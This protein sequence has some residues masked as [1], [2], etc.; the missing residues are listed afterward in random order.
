ML[1]LFTLTNDDL[2]RLNPIEAVKVFRRLLWAEATANGISKTLINVPSAINVADGGIDAEI[3]NVEKDSDQGIIKKGFTRYQIKTGNFNINHDVNINE[4]LFKKQSIEEKKNNKPKELKHR[5]HSCLKK[6]GHLVIVL[7]GWDNPEPV[8]DAIKNKF[9]IKLKKININ[10]EKSKIYIW[11]QNQII[12]FFESFP[13]LKLELISRKLFSFCTYNTWSNWQDMKVPFFQGEN[14]K[15]YLLNLQEELRRERINNPIRVLGEPGIGKTRITLEAIKEDDL[16]PITIYYE[17]PEQLY[18]DKFIFGST[19]DINNYSIILVVD[20]CNQAATSQIWNK[21]KNNLPNIKLVTIFD[22]Y[23]EFTEQTDIIDILPLENEQIK[24]IFYSYLGKDENVN[25]WAEYCSG[26][27]RVAHILGKNLSINSENLL[28]T[29][30]EVD[31]WGIYIAGKNNPNSSEEKKKRN[32]LRYISLFKKFGFGPPFEN[33]LKFIFN[34]IEENHSIKWG[35]FIDIIKEFK[36]R[37][38]LQGSKTLYITPKLLHIYL[39]IEYWNN[40]GSASNFNFNQFFQLCDKDKKDGITEESLNQLKIWFND[41]FKYAVESKIAI[42]VVE[43]ILGPDGPFK[44]YKFLD[45]KPG[46]DFFLN[47]TI[48]SPKYALKC[49]QRLFRNKTKEELLNFQN[50]RRFIIWAL[51]RIIVWRNLFNEGM[52]LLLALAE[53]ENESYSNNATGI[54][55]SRFKQGPRP[56]ATTEA[57]SEER[58]ELLEEVLKSESKEKRIIG[59]KACDSALQ[60]QM[61]TRHIGSEYQGLKKTPE[62][63]APRTY[64]ELWDSYIRVWNLLFKFIKVVEKDEKKLIIEIILRRLRE[65]AIYQN[66][67]DMLIEGI[68]YIIKNNY[69]TEEP[70]L[71]SIS[72]IIYFDGKKMKPEILNKWQE[73]KNKLVGDDFSSLLKR[74]VGMNIRYEGFYKKGKSFSEEDKKFKNQ[75]KDLVKDVIKDKNLLMKELSWLMTSNAKNGYFFGVELGN[76][77]K[78]FSLLKILIDTFKKIK[79]NPDVSFLSGYLNSIYSTDP[80]KFERL[81]D[82]FVNDDKLNTW[83]PEISL[84]TYLSD[85]GVIRILKLAKK[86]IIKTDTFSIFRYGNVT[87]EISLEIF[88]DLIKYLLNTKELSGLSV[89]L[90][91][92]YHYFDNEKNREYLPEEITKDILINDL[93]FKENTKEKSDTMVEY[94]WT[95][96]GKKYL[97]K[98]SNKSIKIAEIIIKNFDKDCYLFNYYSPPYEL[99]NEITYTYPKEIW[100]IVI[101]YLKL[102]NNKLEYAIKMWLE[103]KMSF[104]EEYTGIL[105]VFLKDDIFKWIDEDK[106]IRAQYIAECV[107][108]NLSKGNLTR[109]LLMKYGDIENVKSALMMNFYTGGWTGPTSSHFIEEKKILLDYKKNETDKNIIRWIDEFIDY[110]D[111]VIEDAKIKE[112]RDEW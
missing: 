96:L 91:I 52:K 37:K 112:E 67:T 28:K 54:F 23:P 98:Y 82:D 50:G 104:K 109:E 6:N 70:V 29:P 24:N 72:S 5:I 76:A 51:E 57:S 93:W 81:L 65:L 63:W 10:Y 78:N 8:E 45:S 20:E 7:F 14:Q 48:A 12:S 16:A 18:N 25:R 11:R 90:T 32:I 95:K 106:K 83:I 94:Y 53:A 36:L 100:K 31:V 39:W 15:Q 21:I 71:E 84:K 86:I 4:I 88:L 59:I 46:G 35:D 43:D 74:H 30:D 69:S 79:D 103:G 27:P 75:I 47:L 64:K 26:S 66:F 80:I 2:N 33:E 87:K 73:L 40:I 3:N 44:D 101:K 1:N 92:Y 38:I 105:P 22:E 55:T 56:V 13:A 107:P 34:K 62:L 60:T 99:L 42:K 102:K 97:Q 108:S 68:N 85:Q 41:M 49:L 89:A 17:S 58:F 110:L 111:K 61:F 19:I 77:D 9:I